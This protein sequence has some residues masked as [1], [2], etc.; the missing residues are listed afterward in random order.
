MKRDAY[1]I[2][3]RLEDV[4]FLIQY[5][6]LGDSAV[7]EAKTAMHTD[8]RSPGCERWWQVAKDH[9]EFFRVIEDSKT[10]SL[11]MRYALGGPGRREPLPV[12]IVQDLITIA[13][14]LH[15]RQAKRVELWRGRVTMIAAIVAAVVGVVGLFVKK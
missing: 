9:P 4:I 12:A 5:L 3:N 1:L 13:M 2:P 10:T 8:P 11:N 7:L 6:G 15:E 14:T